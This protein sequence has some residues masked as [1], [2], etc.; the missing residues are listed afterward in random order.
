MVGLA[1]R[2]NT[3][4]AVHFCN[5][6]ICSAVCKGDYQQMSRIGDEPLHVQILH[7]ELDSYWNP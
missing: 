7:I 2:P 5:P 1:C 4:L 3:L 6:R